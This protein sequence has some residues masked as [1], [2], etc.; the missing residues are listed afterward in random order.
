MLLTHMLEIQRKKRADGEE[1]NADILDLGSC[2][3]VSLSSKKTNLKLTF[4]K[5]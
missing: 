1:G 4:A 5:K 2:R 3:F